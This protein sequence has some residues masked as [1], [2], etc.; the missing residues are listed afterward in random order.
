MCMYT[1]NNRDLQLWSSPPPT[2]TQYKSEVETKYARREGKARVGAV[3][4]V[5]AQEVREYQMIKKKKNEYDDPEC[6]MHIRMHTKERDLARK[7]ARLKAQ[8]AM[9]RKA[10]EDLAGYL[11]GKYQVCSRALLCSYVIL[12]M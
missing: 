6:C 4:R 3:Q 10:H 1:C 9:E 11:Q 7:L 2:H 8:D 5:F 12:N